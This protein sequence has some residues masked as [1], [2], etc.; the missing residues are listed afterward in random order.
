M[1]QRKNMTKY[2]AKAFI[3]SLWYSQAGELLTGGVILSRLGKIYPDAEWS[4]RRD[5]DSQ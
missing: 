1:E 3:S 2:V 4:Y 5:D